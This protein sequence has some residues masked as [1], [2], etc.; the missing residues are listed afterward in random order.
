ME[1]NVPRKRDLAPV[2]AALRA[3]IAEF[4]PGLDVLHNEPDRYYLNTRTIGANRHPIA[5][6]GV[7]T[8]KAYVS[9]YLMPIYMATPK[10]SPQLKKRM[11]GK[12]C[13]NFTTVDDELFAELR[14]VT[15][16]GYDAWKAKKWVD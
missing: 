2:F 8:G 3:I 12:A 4:E 6:G 16:H 15:R 9:F 7:R 1:R 13:F 14:T 5:F 10:L 11:Q